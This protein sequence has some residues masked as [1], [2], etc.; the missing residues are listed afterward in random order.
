[1]LTL[2][3][4]SCRKEGETP[5]LPKEATSAGVGWDSGYSMSN[6]VPENDTQQTMKYELD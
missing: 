6:S 3:Q 4:E 5:G 1:M 2:D